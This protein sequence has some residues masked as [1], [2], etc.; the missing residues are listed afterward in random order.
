MVRCGCTPA[1]GPRPLRDQPEVL[2]DDDIGQRAV[3]YYRYGDHAYLK[4][5]E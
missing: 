1:P 4:G 5:H 3:D 2:E